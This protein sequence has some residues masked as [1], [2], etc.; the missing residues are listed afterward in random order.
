MGHVCNE[1]DMYLMK[2]VSFIAAHVAA[3]GF[4]YSF[5]GNSV[6]VHN[7]C[8]RSSVFASS[9][10]LQC[11]VDTEID[12]VRSSIKTTM[13]SRPAFFYMRLARHTP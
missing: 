8:F 12:Q 5:N 1:R 6:S 7:L 4:V 13:Y 3:L 2:N 9:F 10:C 11:G